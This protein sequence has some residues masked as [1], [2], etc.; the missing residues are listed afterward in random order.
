MRRENMMT[1]GGGSD[2]VRAQRPHLAL[3]L[4]FYERHNSVV[5]CPLLLLNDFRQV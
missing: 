1:V 4:L 5:T 3:E 2:L